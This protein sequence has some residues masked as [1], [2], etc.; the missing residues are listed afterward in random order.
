M[1][2]LSGARLRVPR[3][4]KKH[5]V[6]VNTRL[7]YKIYLLSELITLQYKISLRRKLITDYKYK[8]GPAEKLITNYS[9][10]LALSQ[11]YIVMIA[12]HQVFFRETD[13]NFTS[14]RAT[15][16]KG[17]LC[18]AGVPLSS[19]ADG[20]FRLVLAEGSETGLAS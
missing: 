17:L 7:Q 15:H 4:E 9:T 8:F 10:R 1:E 3:E 12:S 6:A 19:R 20:Q 14:E 16:R 2:S 5:G 11:Y 13:R 18:F